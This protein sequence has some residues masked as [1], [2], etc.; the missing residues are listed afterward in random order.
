MK[1]LES[2]FSIKRQRLANLVL[3]SSQTRT[4]MPV[5]YTDIFG[6]L[7]SEFGERNLMGAIDGSD[8]K[9]FA[10]VEKNLV[11]SR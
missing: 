2:R 4:W 7:L 5:P 6:N 1:L 9:F 8:A 10:L 11:A 3:G